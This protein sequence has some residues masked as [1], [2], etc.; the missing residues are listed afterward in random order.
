MTTIFGLG[1]GKLFIDQFRHVE[2]PSNLDE[3]EHSADATGCVLLVTLDEDD[4]FF[5]DGICRGGFRFKYL[6]APLI[7]SAKLGSNH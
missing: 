1:L 3:P 5:A 2:L 4:A 7:L 6:R